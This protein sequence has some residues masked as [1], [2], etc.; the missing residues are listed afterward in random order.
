MWAFSVSV[1]FRLWI[2]GLSVHQ[3]QDDKRPKM[4]ERERGRKIFLIQREKEENMFKT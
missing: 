2:K 1:N 4:G 3:K